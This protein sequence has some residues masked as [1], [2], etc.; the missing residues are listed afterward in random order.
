MASGVG[1]TVTDTE[2]NHD[3]VLLL[4]SWITGLQFLRSGH[5]TGKATT[6]RDS[7]PWADYTLETVPKPPNPP[8]G[9]LSPDLTGPSADCEDAVRES[10]TWPWQQGLSDAVSWP[11]YAAVCTDPARCGT[12]YCA[13]PPCQPPREQHTGAER[14]GPVCVAAEQGLLMRCRGP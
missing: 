14:Y 10:S 9:P 2:I 4:L 7:V 5:R 3:S 11:S 13:V 8:D 1:I 12:V 6:V